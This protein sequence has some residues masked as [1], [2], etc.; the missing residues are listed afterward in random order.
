MYLREPGNWYNVTDDS[1]LIDSAA[2]YFDDYMQRHF[3]GW[4]DTGAYTDRVWT[5]SM[6]SQLSCPLGGYIVLTED[7]VMG[8]TTD[9]LPHIGPIPGKPGQIVIAGF[10]GHGMPQIFLSALGVARMLVE[11]TEYSNIGL[12]RL[13]E[14]TLERL[15]SKENRILHGILSTSDAGESRL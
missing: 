11:G 12:P 7:I 8:Y 5:G 13:F 4:E 2:R 9:L 3:H 1:R 10:N 15:K 14:V 6:F